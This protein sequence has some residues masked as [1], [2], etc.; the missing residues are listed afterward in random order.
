MSPVRL[1][2]VIR[3]GDQTR[4]VWTVFRLSNAP[5][6]ISN[7]S[8]SAWSAGILWARVFLLLPNSR[9]LSVKALAAHCLYPARSA[10]G[11][12]NFG[13]RRNPGAFVA[14]QAEAYFASPSRSALS[15]LGVV[16]HERR[17]RDVLQ[18]LLVRVN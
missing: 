16:H 5:F 18:G 11:G 2:P 13:Y 17:N 14:L 1:G 3:E 15:K 4:I 7:V 10:D 9:R 8:I 12:R 6:L